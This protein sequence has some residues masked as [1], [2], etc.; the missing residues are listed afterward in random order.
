[1]LPLSGSFYGG[2]TITV[3]R[4]LLGKLLC[5]NSAEGLTAGIIVETEAYLSRDDP[6]CHAAR[7]MTRRNAAMFGPPGSSYIY[8]VYGYHYCFNVVTAPPGIGEAVLV[9]ALEPVAGLEMMKHGRGKSRPTELAGGPGMLCQAMGITTAL[10]GRSLQAYPLW[11]C[12][13]PEKYSSVSIELSPRIGISRGSDKLLRF[14][15]RGNQFVSR[16]GFFGSSSNYGKGN[17]GP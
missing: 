7:G 15:L 16:R 12:C 11:I 6:A 5:H 9:R 10:N 8:F 2:D 14:Y 1:L 3:A 17:Q 4:N 13:G